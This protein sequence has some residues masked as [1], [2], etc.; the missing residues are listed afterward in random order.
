MKTVK[1]INP[2]QAG[3]YFENG[4]KPLDIYFSRGKWVWE[5]DKDESN[6][7]RPS[8]LTTPPPISC[9]SSL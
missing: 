8:P 6:P 1:I 9:T 2:V 7:R 5:F 4:L 3:F